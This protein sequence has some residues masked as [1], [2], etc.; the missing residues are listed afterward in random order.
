[1]AVVISLIFDV[2]FHRYKKAHLKEIPLK[3]EGDFF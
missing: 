3:F 1:M 2:I